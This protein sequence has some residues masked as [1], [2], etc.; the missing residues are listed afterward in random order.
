MQD[1]TQQPPQSCRRDQDLPGL[2]TA[3]YDTAV[4]RDNNRGPLEAA[5]TAVLRRVAMVSADLRWRLSLSHPDAALEVLHSWFETYGRQFPT[6][7]DQAMGFL[8]GFVNFEG[9]YGDLGAACDGLRLA[10]N[11]L[12]GR[13]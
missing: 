9:E 3:F 10:R 13:K 7:I 2:L 6:I 8:K 4:G 5:G 12:G 1:T 11:E